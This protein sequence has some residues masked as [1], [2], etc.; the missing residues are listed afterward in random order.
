MGRDLSAREV[1]LSNGLLLEYVAA[2]S[3]PF[4]SI[5]NPAFKAYIESI[6]PSAVQHLPSHRA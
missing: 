6:Q 1:K 2:C 3:V 4:Q 5:E